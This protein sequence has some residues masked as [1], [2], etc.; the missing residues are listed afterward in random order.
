MTKDI[1]ALPK[2]RA[3]T[4]LISRSVQTSFTV[5]PL[6]KLSTLHRRK[7]SGWPMYNTPNIVPDAAVK[8]IQSV[9]VVEASD[10]SVIKYKDVKN[11]P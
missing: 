11:E 4:N 6:S 9:V 7:T 1:S 3:T 8:K 5:V 2:E 10:H